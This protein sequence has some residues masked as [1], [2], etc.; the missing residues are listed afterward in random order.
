[1]NKK[2]RQRLQRREAR[3]RKRLLE[4]QQDDSELDE[5][6]DD[7]EELEEIE[8]IESGN[9]DAEYFK[10]I[11]KDYGEEMMTAPVGGPITFEELDMAR[12]L[13]EKQEQVDEASCDVRQLVSNILYRPD[14]TA[15]SK[16]DA[17]KAVGNE[18]GNRVSSIMDAPPMEKAVDIDLLEIE[19]IFAKEMRHVGVSER[20]T[21]WIEKKKLTYAAEQKL[22]D[23]DFALVI[24]RDGKKIRKYPIHDKAH[25]RNAL[26]RAAQMIKRG[27]AA[28]ADAKAAL[29]KIKAAAKKMGIGMDDKA[30]GDVLIEKDAKGQWRWVG[31][32][33]NNFI[34]WDGDII[35]EAAHLEFVEWVNKNKE[36]MPLSM[37]WHRSESTREHP[38]D[39][40]GYQ[41]GFLIAS[42]PL[43]ER[44]AIALLKM[45]KKTD[46]GMSMGGFV[47]NRDSSDPR[48]ISKYRAVEFSD[49]PLQNAANPFTSFEAL[50]KEAKMDQKQYLTEI[51]G[52]ERAAAFL[53]KTGMQQEALQSAGVISK[54]ADVQEVPAEIQ[55]PQAPEAAN[56]PMDSESIMKAVREDI[57][58]DELNQWVEKANDA[59]AKVSTL[60]ELV[61]SLVKQTEEAK[62]TKEEELAKMIAP[63]TATWAWA[64]SRRASTSTD[65]LKKDGE[66][67]PQPAIPEGDDWWLSQAAGVAPLPSNQ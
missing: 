58:L 43:E 63:P 17:I 50:S 36:F 34:D 64:T 24:E 53:K 61:K 9:D 56:S 2:E 25:V 57:G 51:L 19:S 49:L 13:Q 27:G 4:K 5:D 60:E 46:L 28:A 1:M 52:E 38:C 6:V 23:G 11:R 16:G 32:P 14:L 8:E 22:S 12:D 45:Q 37:S 54:E 42:A 48:V 29:P 3:N 21:D 35:S 59:L 18:F 20:L 62:E 66:E 47:I 10:S 41:N 7:I 39:F 33:S 55:T 15:K 26:A 44:E 65:T 31:M 30:R 40:V 67:V